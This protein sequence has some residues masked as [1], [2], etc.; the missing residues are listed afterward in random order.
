MSET[1]GRLELPAEAPN[2][3]GYTSWPWERKGK[4]KQGGY[5]Y[6][7]LELCTAGPQKLG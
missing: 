5:F 2:I 6:L 1:L 4:D 7:K 3:Q